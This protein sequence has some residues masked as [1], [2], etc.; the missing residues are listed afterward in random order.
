MSLRHTILT[1]LFVRS[2]QF[3]CLTT[4]QVIRV[5]HPETY[6]LILRPGAFACRFHES[7]WLADVLVRGFLS[8]EVGKKM[9]LAVTSSK[10]EDRERRYSV[11]A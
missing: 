4:Q 9:G 10:G 7:D 11:K 1:E 2:Y 5:D 6:R 3:E 8:G